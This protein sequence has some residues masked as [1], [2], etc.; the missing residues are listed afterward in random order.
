MKRQQSSKTIDVLRELPSPL[1]SS[2]DAA[3][4]V[5]DDNMFLFRAS[6]R[7]Y[8]K[9]ITNKVYWNILFSKEPPK[10]EHIACFSRQP[11][12][13]SC[14]WALNYHGVLLQVPY[15]CTAITLHPGFGQRNR[16]KYGDYV[17]EYSRI[18]EKLYLPAEILNQNNV[19]M[20]TPEKALLDTA[21]L[22]HRI[23][24]ADELETDNLNKKKL[25]TLALLFPKRVQKL[26]NE[27]ITGSIDR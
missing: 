9:K 23:L 5:P 2:I 8:I 12:Y 25:K 19:L 26:V 22:R 3:K 4:L 20:A 16:I 15:V 21:H 27:F 17:I 7:G 18:A 6:K 14:E 24:F 1:F 13:I 11:S 10:V